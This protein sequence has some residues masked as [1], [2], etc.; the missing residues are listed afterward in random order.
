MIA[1]VIA[2]TAAAAG[3]VLLAA[4]HARIS[5]LEAEL[6]SKAVYQEAG[7]RDAIDEIVTLAGRI[8]EHEEVTAGHERRLEALEER[9]LT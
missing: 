8:D 5:E 9:V 7:T 6:E 4:A 2:G 3:A 1:R